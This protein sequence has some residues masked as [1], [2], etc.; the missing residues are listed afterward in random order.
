[1]FELF[2]SVS[3]N[4]ASVRTTGDGY[5]VA[6][7]RVARTGIQDYLGSE[8]DHPEMALVRVY[9]PPEAVFAKDAMSSYA[10]KPMTNDHKGEI[11]SANWRDHSVGQIGSEVVRDGEF[12]RVP[13]VLMDASAIADYRSGKRELSMGYSANIEFKDGVT[14]EGES[15]NAIVKDMRMNHLALVDRARGGESLRIGDHGALRKPAPQEPT[16]GHQMPDTRKV[17]FDG[18]EIETTAQ[19]AQAIDKLAQKLADA[20]TAQA[21]A[22]AAHT[23]VLA[24]RDGKLA[25]AEAERDAALAKVMDSAAVDKLVADRA[26][27]LSTAKAIHDADYTGKT[28]E[29][30]KHAVVVAKIGDAAV[31]GKSADYVAARFDI[32]AEDAAT[33]PVRRA[34]MQQDGGRATVVD[35]DKAYDASV[36][37]MAG[38]WKQK[39]AA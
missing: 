1:M 22:D 9:R 5:L 13:M 14:P 36:A 33:D 6:D 38:A 31:A 11:T 7:V 26:A 15:Y 21:R 27:L 24:D 35:S 2:D 28:P 10:F 39:A 32:L 16:G 3:V 23:T 17:M 25:K 18:L 30:I 12:V 19:G 34:V 37:R 20:A 4:D 8:L 29:Q